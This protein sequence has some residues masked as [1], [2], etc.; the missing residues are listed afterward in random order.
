MPTTFHLLVHHQLPTAADPAAPDPH[1]DGEPLYWDDDE[2]DV[3]VLGLYST[4]ARAEA[5]I[6]RARTLPGFRSAPDGFAVLEYALDAPRW[7]EGFH[8]DAGTR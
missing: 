4:R 7:P 8:I 5:R 3:K 6:E 2:D 1:E